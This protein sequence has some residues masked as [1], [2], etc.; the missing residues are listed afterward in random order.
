M[1]HKK[2]IALVIDTNILIDITKTGNSV[3]IKT[4]LQEWLLKIIKKMD[5]QPKGKTI[6]VF[7]SQKTL[8]DYKSGLISAG[9]KD[10]GE[11][12]KQIFNSSLTHKFAISKP[13]K[14]YFSLR[15]INTDN[16]K[17]Q[18]RIG[19]RNDENFLIL[20][21]KIFTITSLKEYEIIF[22]SRDKKSGPEIKHILL[23][24]KD[25]CRSHVATDLK[26]FEKLIEC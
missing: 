8:K 15:R 5:K 11:Q 19:D 21:E 4:V 6:T 2:N 26:C 13:Q 12:I 25:R 14:I 17:K 16:L 7:A 22:S 23:K 3:S 20:I 10:V 1:I 18:R 9:Y 24:T